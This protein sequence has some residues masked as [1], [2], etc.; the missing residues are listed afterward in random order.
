MPPL[1]LADVPKGGNDA[2]EGTGACC[3]LPYPAAGIA[4][5]TTLGGAA[6]ADSLCAS[7]R[8]C[9]D[10]FFFCALLMLGSA[11]K[12][13]LRSCPLAPEGPAPDEDVEG[14]PPHRPTGRMVPAPAAP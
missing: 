8:F 10:S 9:S 7:E 6:A 3:A 13:S 11:G 4:R 14:P 1:P 2:A 5:L 12:S